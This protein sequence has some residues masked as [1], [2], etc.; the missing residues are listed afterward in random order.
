MSNF[1]IIKRKKDD[2][3]LVQ[4]KQY[5]GDYDGRYLYWI[6]STIKI[7]KKLNIVF[8]DIPYNSNT[9]AIFG[10]EGEA[11]D[12]ILGRLAEIEVNSDI[13]VYEV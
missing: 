6:D 13:V 7:P 1:R 12:Y 10:E 5:R 9:K 4:E 11:K 8:C 3:Y 2:K